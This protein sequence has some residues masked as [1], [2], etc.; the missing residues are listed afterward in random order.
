MLISAVGEV[1]DVREGETVHSTSS[2]FDISV[3]AG[4]PFTAHLQSSASLVDVSCSR[5]TIH[6]TSSKLDIS[7]AVGTIQ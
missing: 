7:A 6:R 2:K 5:R 4:G 3:V 1:L